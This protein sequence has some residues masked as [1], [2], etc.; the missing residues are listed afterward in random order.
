[1]VDGTRVICTPGSG[2]PMLAGLDNRPG[3]VV[4]R[5]PMPAGAQ[6]GGDGAAYSSIVISQGGGVKQYV[7]LVGRGDDET[8]ADQGADAAHVRLPRY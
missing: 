8:A 4:W 3:N 1:M 7:Q 2:T 6:A 5:A